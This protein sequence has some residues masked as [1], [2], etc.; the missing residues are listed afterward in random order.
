[1]YE[2]IIDNVNTVRGRYLLRVVNQMGLTTTF[3]GDGSAIACC[4]VQ[5]WENIGSMADVFDLEEQSRTD[6]FRNVAM[7]NLNTQM[8]NY[9]Y[10][11]TTGHSC[12]VSDCERKEDEFYIDLL[13][14]Y[15]KHYS[16]VKMGNCANK[17]CLI[18][19]Y[20]EAVKNGAVDE[21]PAKRRGSSTSF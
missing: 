21:N 3:V 4:T 15:E 16:K 13:G 6:T 2:C 18:Q 17:M 19:Q 20:E 9:S 14:W 8:M 12:T 1:M 11:K 5:Q 7:S 10:I